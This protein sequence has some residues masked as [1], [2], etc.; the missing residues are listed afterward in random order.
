MVGGQQSGAFG[1]N[2]VAVMIRVAGEGEVKLIL[3]P[4]QSL[5][6]ISGGW[7]HPYLTIPIHGHKP[8]GGINHF[9]DYGEI[10]TI[11]LGDSRPI[12][13]AG[14]A[15]RINPQP[16]L[17]MADEIHVN[18]AAKIGDVGTK[19]VATPRGRGAQSFFVWCA[20]HPF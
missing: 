4:D 16:E 7:V 1:D 11:S 5:H 19:V 13:D 17:R 8:E 6:G 9:V 20:F 10:Q 12:M 2:A 18:N 14:T 15:Q 3:H